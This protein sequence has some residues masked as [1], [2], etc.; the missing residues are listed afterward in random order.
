MY[1]YTTID[2]NDRFVKLGNGVIKTERPTFTLT[3][4]SQIETV[5]G[6]QNSGKRSWSRIDQRDRNTGVEVK[7]KG[8]KRRRGKGNSEGHKM[9][10]NAEN[11]KAVRT[12]IEGNR[13]V[14]LKG[15]GG[16]G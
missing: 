13:L 2:N 7:T 1:I 12:S 6:G 16:L 5:V 11:P 14:K 8:S 4:L 9:F 3:K 15:G 10:E